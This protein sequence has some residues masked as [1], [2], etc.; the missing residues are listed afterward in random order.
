MIDHDFAERIAEQQRQREETLRQQRKSLLACL[1]K[2]GI[3]QVKADYDGYADSGN[4]GEIKLMPA[5]A[6]LAEADMIELTDFIWTTAYNANPGFEIE[7]GG[8]GE[9]L[10]DIGT[11]RIKVIHHTHVMI[12][13]TTTH[14]NI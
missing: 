1:N 12:H 9:F 2:A 6:V 5:D 10:W 11:D 8:H 7:D 4:V 14:T 3:K 13:E